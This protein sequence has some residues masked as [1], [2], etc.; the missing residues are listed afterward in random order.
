MSDVL[1]WGAITLGAL[2]TAVSYGLLTYVNRGHR[3]H[4]AWRG[5]K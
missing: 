5:A 3:I 1:A 2:L 4:K